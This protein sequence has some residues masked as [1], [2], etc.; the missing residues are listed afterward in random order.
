[1]IPY[2]FGS[3]SRDKEENEDTKYRKDFGFDAKVGLSSSLN[4]DLTYNPDFS[5]AEVDDQVT[6]LEGYELYFP[7]K[8]QFFLENSDLFARSNIGAIFVN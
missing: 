8:R 2:L 4:L 1:M 3:A 5:Q 6:N 7:E